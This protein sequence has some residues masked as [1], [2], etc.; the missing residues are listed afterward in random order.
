MEKKQKNSQSGSP[1]TLTPEEAVRI[2]RGA[3]IS[4][5]TDTL[6]D[7]IEAKAVP[8]GIFILQGKRQFIISRK[9]FIEW[10]DEFFGYKFEET[11]ETEVLT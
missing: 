9:L 11:T 1:L 10:L 4:I 7:M 3:G 6:R 5:A 8:F 2:M